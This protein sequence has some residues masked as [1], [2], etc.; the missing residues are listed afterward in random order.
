MASPFRFKNQ[1][2][3]VYFFI[4]DADSATTIYCNTVGLVDGL[5]LCSTFSCENR[6]S[7]QNNS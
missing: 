1:R 6:S 2:L 3:V 5:S 7:E 4:G